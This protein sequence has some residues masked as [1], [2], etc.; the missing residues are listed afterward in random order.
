M[1]KIFIII[2]LFTNLVANSQQHEKIQALNNYVNFTNESIH[3]LLIIHRLLENF[4]QEVNKFVDLPGYKINNISNGDLPLNIFK[5]EDHWFYNVTPFEYFEKIKKDKYVIGEENYNL[6]FP[7]ANNLEQ[8]NNSINALRFEIADF[9]SNADLNTKEDLD[10]IY[11]LLEEAVDLFD[12]FYAYELN[13]EDA[14]L[15]IFPDDI[16]LHPVNELLQRYNE[17][18]DILLSIR[19]KNSLKLSDKINNLSTKLNSK[20]PFLIKPKNNKNS[21]L[22]EKIYNSL[23]EIVTTTRELISSPKISKEYELYGV[24]YYYYNV[25]LIDKYNRYGNGFIKFLNNLIIKNNIPVLNRLEFPHYFKVIYPERIAKTLKTI[26]STKTE[27]KTIPKKLDGREVKYDNKQKILVEDYSVEL[28]IFDYKIQDGDIIS[29]NFNG[30]WIFEKLSLETK[31]TKI[32]LNLNKKGK[33]YIVLHA[34]NVGRQPPNTIGLSYFFHGEKKT[35]I[36]QSDL[37]K[38]EMVELEVM[39]NK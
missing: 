1:K 39:D 30:D 22:R 2:F 12:L 13:L 35:I 21:I 9:I 29:L 20:S 37:R 19:V 24:Y 31:P 33:N 7:I 25:A 18:K 26:Q 8:T 4:N 36:M 38:S 5:D 27:I 34:V 23:N 11:L 17:A 15:K 3:G 32:K 10:K 28:E 14:L 16:S 6:L